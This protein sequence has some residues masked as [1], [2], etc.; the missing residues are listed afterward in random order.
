MLREILRS[1]IA[2]FE[3]CTP[4]TI[5]DSLEHFGRVAAHNASWRDVF[6]DDCAGCDCGAFADNH[7]G[8]DDSC[9]SCDARS[10]QPLKP[11]AEADPQLTYPAVVLN[12]DGL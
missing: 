4:V 9:S 2:E 7:T 12:D 1:T 6:G 5:L 3:L 10:R 8:A 11:N